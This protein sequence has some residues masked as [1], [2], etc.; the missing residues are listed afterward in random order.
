MIFGGA[1]NGSANGFAI[2]V[3]IVEDAVPKATRSVSSGPCTG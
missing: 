3:S 1:R 2:P